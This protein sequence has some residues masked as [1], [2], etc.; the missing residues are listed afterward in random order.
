[1]ITQNKSPANHYSNKTFHSTLVLITNHFPYNHGEAFIEHE[2]AYLAQA[3]SR[4]III[5]REKNPVSLRKSTAKFDL[6]RINPKSNLLEKLLLPFLFISKARQARHFIRTEKKFL[7]HTGKKIGRNIIRIY[8]HD[9]SKALVTAWHIQKILRQHRVTGKVILYSYW[10][11]SSSLALTFVKD[12]KL[13]IKTITRGHGSD[14]YEELHPSGYLS[15]RPALIKYLDAVFTISAFGK[16]YLSKYQHENDRNKIFV[17]RL[18]TSTLVPGNKKTNNGFLMVSCSNMIPLKRLDYIVE[19]LEKTENIAI[20]WIHVGE[21]PERKKIEALAQ[22][23][24]SGR[25]N[26]SYTFMGQIPNSAIR[27]FYASNHVDVFV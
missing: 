7:S 23:K 3:F 13:D 1:M 6:H 9:L 10:M 5:T 20:S 2:I 8:L 4:I 11:N 26:I 24:L 25:K 22:Q 14:I 12:K 27:E 18:G 19:A 16:K 15:F 21:G 17:S